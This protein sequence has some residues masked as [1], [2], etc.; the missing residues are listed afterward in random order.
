MS[1]AVRLNSVNRVVECIE[2]PNEEDEN[3]SN[4]I[5]FVL[6]LKGTWVSTSGKEWPYDS[7]VTIGCTF[8]PEKNKFI[9]D[10]PFDNWVLDENELW[11]PPE[12]NNLRNMNFGYENEVSE[13][14][15]FIWDQERGKWGHIGVPPWIL[16]ERERDNGFYFISKAKMN[17]SFNDA[18]DYVNGMNVVCLPK[19]YVYVDVHPDWEPGFIYPIFRET[20]GKKYNI[21]NSNPE[22]FYSHKNYVIIFDGAPYYFIQ[23]VNLCDLNKPIKKNNAHHDVHN[24]YEISVDLENEHIAQY[25]FICG[26]TMSELFKLIIDWDLEYHY[27]NDRSNTA[28][29]CHNILSTIDMPDDIY[30]EIYDTTP[31]SILRRYLNGDSEYYNIGQR[32]I[33]SEKILE[34]A[35]EKYWNLRYLKHHQNLNIKEYNLDHYCK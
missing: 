3:A 14:P 31:E 10:K 23:H 11:V 24:I 21:L 8:I 7:N 22:R 30:K 19:S 4:F 34:W 17:E 2:I 33:T 1:L 15:Q 32:P 12:K 9:I 5:N 26:R 13:G 18:S 29:I 27:S 6:K 20:Y 35:A 28:T 25:P 16:G